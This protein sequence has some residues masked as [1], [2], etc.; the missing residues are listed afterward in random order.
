MDKLKI[1]PKICPSCKGRLN[2][3]S[4]RCTVC[5]TRIEGDYLLPVILQLPPDDQ[6]FVLDFV[7]CSGSLK[8]M[9]RKMGLSYP[10]VRNRLDEIISRIQEYDPSLNPSSL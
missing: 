4:L 6:Q 5:D 7:L 8:E 2:V 9:A 3:Q 10:T 1:L